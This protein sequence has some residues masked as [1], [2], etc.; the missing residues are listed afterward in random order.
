MGKTGEPCV[1][2]TRITAMRNVVEEKHGR[3]VLDRAL[4]GLPAD[5]RDE[6]LHATSVTWI[7][8]ST[9]YA[10]H[11]AVALV[12]GREPLAFHE[13][14]LRLAMERTFRTVWKILLGLVTDA[15]LVARAPSIYARTRDTGELT[16]QL[17]APG[18]AD[19]TLRNYPGFLAR[20][21]RSIGAGLE[22]V[23]GLTGR[24]EPRV[25]GMTLQ[26]DGA[27]FTIQWQ[28]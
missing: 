5:V 17:V 9:D 22:V 1:A 25:T 3:D 15:A 16:A 28:V 6:Y 7:R 24:R 18:R 23:L 27:V 8:A 14:T 2:G 11:D 21:G 19:F 10:V 12:L 20:D 26:P 4:V 13:E